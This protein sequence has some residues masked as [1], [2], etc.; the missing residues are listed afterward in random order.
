MLF[1]LT[2]TAFKSRQH[3]VLGQTCPVKN[4]T[5]PGLSHRESTQRA[6]SSKTALW[7]KVHF[8]SLL[9]QPTAGNEAP[10]L[11][12]LTSSIPGT[13]RLT[14]SSSRLLKKHQRAHCMRGLHSEVKDRQG[15]EKLKSASQLFQGILDIAHTPL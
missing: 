10:A 3:L 13:T 2:A 12:T 11:L 15:G 5:Q 8:S 1:T 4:A 7:N 9:K 6:G 14:D